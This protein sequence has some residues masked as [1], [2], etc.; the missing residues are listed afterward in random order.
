MQMYWSDYFGDTRH[1]TCEQHG[2]YLQLIGSMWLAGGSLPNDPRK[3]AKVTGCSASRW[4]KIADDVLDLFTIEDGQL[5]HKRVTF[6]LEKANEKSIKRA[7][8]GS[9]G[10]K[11]KSLKTQETDEA[12]AT[13]LLKHLPEPEP[14][15]PIGPQEGTGGQSNELALESPSKPERDEVQE[16]F[17]LW[18]ETAH[19]CGLPVAKVLDDA[20][21]RAIRKRLEMGGIETWKIAL[22]AVSVSKFLRGLRPGSD[23]RCFRADLTFICQA[24]SFNRLIEGG[25]GEDVE[26]PQAERPVLEEAPDAA[27]RRRVMIYRKNGHWNRLE[28]GP[29]PGKAGCTVAPEILMAEG[30][31]PTKT[32]EV[33]Q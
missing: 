22:Q 13:G 28:W 29:A 3:L 6:E 10:G 1:L 27:W 33:A 26:A 4:A 18:N 9:L 5:T 30:F 7:K 12:I 14:D 23:G 20:R 21:R 8:A 32:P 24:R 19:R 17:N 31:T 16:A 25:Y 11:S 15:T 2:A